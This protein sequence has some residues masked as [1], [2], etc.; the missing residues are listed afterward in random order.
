MGKIEKCRNFWYM[1][2]KMLHQNA[3]CVC[4]CMRAHMHACMLVKWHQVT[5]DLWQLQETSDDGQV[6]C[7][8]LPLQSVLWWSPIQYWPCSASKIWKLS[9]CTTL[10]PILQQLDLGKCERCRKPVQWLECWTRMG[11]NESQS[12]KLGSP[13][14]DLR[15]VTF[16]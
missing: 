9:G 8:C 6:V 14:S 4:A 3:V 5:A 7:H 13:S 11:R 1:Q 12:L 10:F 2:Y 16:S 15:P